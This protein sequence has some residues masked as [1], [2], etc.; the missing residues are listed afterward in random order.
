[1]PTEVIKNN[2]QTTLLTPID[3]ND[4]V[5]TPV[6]GSGF[7]ATGE[8]V[9]AAIGDEILIVTGGDGPQFDVTRGA[10][11]TTAVGHSAGDAVR[12]VLTAGSFDALVSEAIIDQA[13]P[14][15][16]DAPVHFD[17]LPGA[18]VEGEQRMQITDGAAYAGFFASVNVTAGEGRAS[19]QATSG[20]AETEIVVQ[21]DTV[22]V[23]GLPG[24]TGT[25][26][27]A[28]GKTVTVTKGLIA[29]IV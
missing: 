8:Q 21:P 3:S 28:D 16:T 29:G 12:L 24:S 13:I 2:V 4:T 22:Y 18:G 20:V 15:G 19:L 9:R 7:P 26:T 6:D 11:G 10:E 23:D 5:I 25:F 17:A 1:M 27:S 14:L